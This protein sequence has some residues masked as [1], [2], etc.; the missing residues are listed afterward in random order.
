[1]PRSSLSYSFVEENMPSKMLVD[2]MANERKKK[3]KKTLP[4]LKSEFRLN[5]LKWLNFTIIYLY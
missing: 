3:R 4:G 5:F 2:L 1:M